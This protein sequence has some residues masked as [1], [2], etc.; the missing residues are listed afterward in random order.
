MKVGLVIMD[1]DPAD[2]VRVAKAADRAGIHSVWTID[3]Y[4]RSSLTRAAIMAAVTDTVLVGTSVTPLFARS[5]LALASAAQDIAALSNGRYVLGVGS[6]TRRMNSDWYGAQL[7]HP[8]AQ[9]AER[10]ALIRQLM[11][12]QKGRFKFD[13][14]FDTISMAHLEREKPPVPTPI[15]VAGVGP[16]MVK[17]AAQQGNGFVGHTIASADYLRDHANPSLRRELA[18][19]DRAGEDFVLSSQ[20]IASVDDADPAAA[21]CRAATQVGF[22]STVKGYDALFPGGAFNDERIAARV[23]F[24]AGDIDGVAAA[25]MD[26]AAERATFGT[27]D[28]VAQQLERY[29]DCVDWVLLY[30]PHYGTTGADITANELK[31]I[32]VAKCWTS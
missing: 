18:S 25:G 26:M 11:S 17:V 1:E 29:Q 6:S 7:E 28:D 9:T 19:A 21:R 10:I 31:L 24:A 23:A 14:R 12:H 5:G 2:V 20:V 27:V 32:E 22:Y 8:S 4:N 30:P 15:L 16:M 3:Y 13:G